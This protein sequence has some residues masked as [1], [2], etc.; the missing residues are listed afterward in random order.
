MNEPI[1]T[2]EQAA[3]CLGILKAAEK[4]MTA[5]EIATH[6]GIGGAHETQRRHIRAIVKQLRDGGSMI[7]ANNADGYWLTEDA[8]I[9]WAYMQKRAIDAK[10]ILAEVSSRKKMLADKKGQGMLF[11]NRVQVGCATVGGE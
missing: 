9:F 4:F 2:T 3:R 10:V 8:D 7:I 11:D 1:I 5:A 6:L